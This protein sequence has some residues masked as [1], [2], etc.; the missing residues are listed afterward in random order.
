MTSTGFI[1]VVRLLLAPIAA[2][3]R[4]KYSE[5]PDLNYLLSSVDTSPIKSYDGN[6]RTTVAH[7]RCTDSH[8][9][10]NCDSDAVH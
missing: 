4:A 9:L 1:C 10:A 7:R 8:H 5:K 3:H 2:V 6:R